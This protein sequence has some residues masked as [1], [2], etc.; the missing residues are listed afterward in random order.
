MK[1][2]DTKNCTIYQLL[3]GRSNSFLINSQNNYILID[4][5][6]ANSW[7]KLS[8][9]I[10]EILGKNKLSCLILTHTH[11]DHVENAAKINEKYKSIIIVHQSESEYIMLGNSPLPKGSNLATG[12]MT[13]VLGK[14]LE[15]R[16]QYEKVNPDINVDEKYDLIDFGFNSYIIHTPGHSK[17]SISIIID[18]EVAVVGD[19]MFRVF[20]NS[21]YPP[22]ADDPDTMVKSWNKLI[23]TNCDLFLPGHGKEIS[24]KLLESQYEKY[25]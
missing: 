2:W 4:T 21:I 18:H 3:E 15:S 23:N 14:K 17:G 13:E 24:R 5:G 11:F 16:Y 19:A 6:R 22:F 1:T 25:K 20:G 9:K 12:F 10:D 7:E 8:N